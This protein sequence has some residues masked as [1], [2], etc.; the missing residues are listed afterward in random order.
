MKGSLLLYYLKLNCL[1]CSTGLK[2]LT[3]Y[4]YTDTVNCR[5]ALDRLRVRMNIILLLLQKL[6][7]VNVAAIWH[8][9]FESNCLREL[10]TLPVKQRFIQWRI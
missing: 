6:F 9:A 10:F 7:I 8:A 1:I 3:D 5:T 2:Q 4:V